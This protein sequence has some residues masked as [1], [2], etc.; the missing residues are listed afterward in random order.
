MA[1]LVVDDGDAPAGSL[2]AKGQTKLLALHAPLAVEG[3]S[4]E[5]FVAVIALEAGLEFSNFPLYPYPY[6]TASALTFRAH[7]LGD[8]HRCSQD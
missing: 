2:H 6:I 4:V 8:R 5:E 7:R 1:S 3:G